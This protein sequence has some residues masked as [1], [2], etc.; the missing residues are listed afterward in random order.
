MCWH[1]KSCTASEWDD[2]IAMQCSDDV[3]GNNET[4]DQPVCKKSW[5]HNVDFR[6][7]G[8]EVSGKGEI[9]RS[10]SFTLS[11]AEGGNSKTWK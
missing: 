2:M 5:K 7:A 8:G 6:Y 9:L 1:K 10:K 4:W 3:M 11:E